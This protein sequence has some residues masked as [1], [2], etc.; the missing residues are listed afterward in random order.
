MSKKCLVLGVFALA[1]LS[2]L[3]GALA[4]E[5]WEN[6]NCKHLRP[7]GPE[8]TKPNNDYGVECRK[9]PQSTADFQT[10]QHRVVIFCDTTMPG[11]PVISTPLNSLIS[12]SG[13]T[14][15]Q[16]PP[17]E[18]IAIAYVCPE[19]CYTPRQKLLFN[20]SYQSLEDAYASDAATVT[21]LSDGATSIA[22]GT[23][24]QPVEE[25]TSKGF[26]GDVFTLMTDGG[27]R[28]EVTGN[29]PMVKHD[30]SVVQAGNLAVGDN[31]LMSTGEIASVA[32][33]STR[34]YSG[35]VW[36]INPT[37]KKKQEN[38]LVT[39]GGLLTGSL[40]FQNQWKEDA[41]RLLRADSFDV[42][43]L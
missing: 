6:E 3:V 14:G 31:L 22:M 4:T 42:S 1:T 24:E 43:G 41:S 39:T 26:D 40:K 30:G 18:T 11:C 27:Q 25:F 20:G 16:R 34:H 35:P 33:I 10:S 29:H 5:P 36:N 2:N 17:C 12:S 15:T 9:Y 7:F 37:S 21:T 13:Y 38:I 28:V 19:E 23:G 8:K 32:G